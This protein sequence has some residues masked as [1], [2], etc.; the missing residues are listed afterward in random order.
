MDTNKFLP[1]VAPETQVTGGKEPEVID[2]FIQSGAS[3]T[4]DFEICS[5]EMWK[6]LSESYGFDYEVRRYYKQG[7]WSYYT[8]LEVSMK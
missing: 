2:R 1:G 5:T 4:S 6:F 3:E 8:S 7:S